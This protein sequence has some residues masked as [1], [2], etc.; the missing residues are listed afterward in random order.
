MENQEHWYKKIGMYPQAVPCYHCKKQKK[1]YIPFISK[2][3]FG[4]IA[5]DEK[6]CEK[7][8]RIIKYRP[9]SA[10]RQNLLNEAVA[11]NRSELIQ[12]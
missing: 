4:L 10:N 5:D 6:C 8:I 12:G 9:R 3:H 7:S 2:D 11:R 1:L